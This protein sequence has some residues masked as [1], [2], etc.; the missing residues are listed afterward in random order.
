M[1]MRYHASM[2]NRISIPTWVIY[3]AFA[4]ALTDF[5]GGLCL[6]IKIGFAKGQQVAAERK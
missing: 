4:F 3:L 6:G 1:L 5:V 2:S